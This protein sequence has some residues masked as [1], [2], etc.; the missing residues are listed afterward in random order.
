MHPCLVE[1]SVTYLVD[2]VS[3]DPTEDSFWGHRK[4]GNGLRVTP[5]G[6]PDFIGTGTVQ[7]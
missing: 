7:S 5:F 1:V 6:H 3:E 2:I 4:K